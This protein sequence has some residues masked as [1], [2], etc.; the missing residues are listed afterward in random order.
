MSSSV[1]SA[2]T[3]I[4]KFP[5]HPIAVTTYQ[6]SKIPSVFLTPFADRQ[7]SIVEGINHS[8]L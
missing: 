5:L 2:F 7:L 6:H 3:H 8:I 4:S 1:V